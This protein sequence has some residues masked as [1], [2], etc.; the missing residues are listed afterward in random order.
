VLDYANTGDPTM[1]SRDGSLTVVVA[2][3]GAVNEKQAVTALQHAIAAQP[4][5]KGNTWLGGPTVADVQIAAVSSQGPR[6]GRALRLAFLDPPAVL[7][8]PWP[9]GRVHAAHRAPSSPSP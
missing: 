2:T 6:S 1:I 4:S 3:V 7:H 8:L 9:A 5:L